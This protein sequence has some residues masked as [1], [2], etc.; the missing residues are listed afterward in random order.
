MT[1]DEGHKLIYMTSLHQC[2]VQ[3]CQDWTNI[4]IKQHILAISASCTYWETRLSSVYKSE[5]VN[6]ANHQT[7]QLISCLTTQTEKYLRDN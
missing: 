5:N 7:R 3:G 1:T 6:I 2:S 4:N